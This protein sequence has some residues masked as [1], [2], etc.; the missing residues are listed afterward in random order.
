VLTVAVHLHER[1]GLDAHRGEEL[2][3]LRDGLV[4]AEDAGEDG[5][6]R[7]A[8]LRRLGGER[9]TRSA[10]RGVSEKETSASSARRRG[11][12]REPRDAH[13]RYSARFVRSKRSAGDSVAIDISV[14]QR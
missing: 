5:A 12:E 11:R 13:L 9:F 4:R 8:S 14:G 7:K 3:R 2:H 6:R 10:S 1:R